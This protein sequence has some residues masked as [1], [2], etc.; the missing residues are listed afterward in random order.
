M[1]IRIN[2]SIG[3]A[4]F[5]EDVKKLEAGYSRVEKGV[6]QAGK[7]MGGAS[8]QL[9]NFSRASKQYQSDMQANAGQ[10]ANLVA[11]FND[12]SVMMAAGQSP[13]QL[14]MQ[15]GTQISQVLTQMGGGVGALRALGGAFIGMLNPISLATIGFIAFG[16]YFGQKLIPMVGNWLGFG[17]DLKKQ[18]ESLKT[19]TDAYTAAAKDASIPISELAEKYGYLADE[20]ERAN[21]AGLGF[22]KAQTMKEMK[23]VIQSV[24]NDTF[25]KMFGEDYGAAFVPSDTDRKRSGGLEDYNP[26]INLLNDQ[27]DQLQAKFKLSRDEAVKLNNALYGMKNA[28]DVKD[29]VL[30][31]TQ[32]LAIYDKLLEKG[33][34]EE[35]QLKQLQTDRANINT[36]L[37]NGQAII[38]AETKASEKSY[39]LAKQS[40]EELVKLTGERK[41]AFEAMN[42]AVE[43]GDKKTAD[44]WASIVDSQDNRIKELTNTIT[45]ESKKWA[46]A[47]DDFAFGGTNAFDVI[48]GLLEKVGLNIPKVLS[49]SGN[50]GGIVD[51]KIYDQAMKDMAKNRETGND[52]MLK[53]I[54]AA[55]AY[56]GKELGISIHDALSLWNF[57]SGWNP[58]VMGGDNGKYYGLN[59]FGPN[60][61]SKYGI[62]PGS[63]VMDQ[64]HAVVRF[65]RDRGFDSSI[66]SK[67]NYYATT[68]AGNP[69]AVNAQDS[70]GTRATD[71]NSPKYARAN[72]MAQAALDTYPELVEQSEK[73]AENV[74]RTEKAQTDWAKRIAETTANAKSEAEIVKLTQVEIDK[75]NRDSTLSEKQKRDAIIEVEVER[76]RRIELMRLE[77]DAKQQGIDLDAMNIELGRTYHEII[78]EQANAIAEK[79]RQDAIAK[80]SMQDYKKELK[81]TNK[82]GQQLA[83]TFA[84][85]FSGIVTGSMTAKQALA[86]LISFLGN[87]LIKNLGVWAGGGAV[88]GGIMN[89]AFGSIGAH[90]NGGIVNTDYQIV[91]ERGKELVQLPKGSRVNTA[92][93]TSN[94]MRNNNGIAITIHSVT[95]GMV[96]QEILETSANASAKMIDKSLKSYDKGTNNR[97]REYEN[98]TWAP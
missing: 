70:N 38:E 2:A 52:A 6:A 61:Q 54:I 86:Q 23:S 18:F 19:V 3:T 71:V 96:R 55:G 8:A 41:T 88:K 16:A 45:Q 48:N 67:E 74:I 66:H 57:E 43:A 87:N 82:V 15:Q 29:Q 24:T 32:V 65:N 60:E 22:A 11:Q 5:N 42:K 95:D 20:I 4:Q 37:R 73:V 40:A 58:Q 69:N 92:Q 28:T 80:A 90:A 14:A 7:A 64:A 76:A 84:N 91:G 34:I 13:I 1:S 93:Q 72:A 59:Q 17:E 50:S 46:S 53:E 77:N 81:D 51:A 79:A 44:R 36:L 78:N 10:T 56:V 25:G 94:I 63:S 85:I 30:Y 89:W 49:G 68:L 26:S 9:I 35:K 75:I 62:G 33:D 31:L 39:N 83:Q 21:N 47:W 12:I 98:N 27:L 97:I